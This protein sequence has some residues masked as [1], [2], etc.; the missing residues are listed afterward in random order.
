MIEEFRDEYR[1]LSNFWYLET[2]MKYPDGRGGYHY[3]ETNEHFYVAMKTIDQDIRKQVEEH[4]LKGLKKFGN[5]FPLREDWDEI[6]LDVMEYGLRYKFSEANPILRQQLI[7]TG[8]Q[9]IQE[10][11]NWGDIYWGICLKTWMG[12]N[13][14]GKLLMKI[15][16]E[17]IN[18]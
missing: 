4:P 14:L 15:R 1:F 3:F 6:K 12:E 2:P 5:T 16:E 8:D 7:N 18:A 13:N 10:G 17:T 9:E 11:N